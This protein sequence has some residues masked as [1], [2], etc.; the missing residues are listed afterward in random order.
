MAILANS[1]TH[2]TSMI[3]GAQ[4]SPGVTI[5]RFHSHP[6]TIFLT[7]DTFDVTPTRELED[8]SLHTQF[9]DAALIQT[10]L[11]THS[12]CITFSSSHSWR[13][14]EMAEHTTGWSYRWWEGAYTNTA[15]WPGTISRWL[16]IKW[17]MTELDSITQPLAIQA[18]THR[19]MV[20]RGL[21]GSKNGQPQYLLDNRGHHVGIHL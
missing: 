9:T 12:T 10:P 4:A 13:H 8:I 1:S 11:L 6:V 3:T 7:Q 2:R 21:N 14:I 20:E 18:H 15:T 5:T 16:W 17:E 19:M